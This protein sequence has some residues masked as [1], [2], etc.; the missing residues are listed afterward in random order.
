MIVI[1]DAC[2]MF[3]DDEVVDCEFHLGVLAV[4]GEHREMQGRE[5]RGVGVGVGI[6]IMLL[7]IHSSKGSFVRLRKFY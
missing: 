6:R 2:I 1:C 3:F 5:V 4:S 7:G